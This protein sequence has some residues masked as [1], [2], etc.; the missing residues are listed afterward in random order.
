MPRRDS[1]GPQGEGSKTGAQ[2]GVC[3]W[4][5]NISFDQWRGNMWCGMRRWRWY[6]RR[7]YQQVD[8]SNQKIIDAKKTKS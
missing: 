6:R 8:L 7:N 4:A 2:M 1:T 5:R 3:E